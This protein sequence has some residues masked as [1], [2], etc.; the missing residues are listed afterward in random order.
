[1]RNKIIFS[2]TII[3]LGIMVVSLGLLPGNRGEEQVGQVLGARSEASELEMNLPS[4]GDL[5]SPPVKTN[6]YEP[7]ISVKAAI[8]VDAK[9]AYPLYQENEL[10]QVPIASTTKIMTAVI[11]LENYNVEDEIT[12]SSDATSTIGSSINLRAD[13]V[14]TVDSLLKG[15]LIQSGNDAA[16]TLAEKM[17]FDRFVS[18]MN[19][20]AVE[21]GMVNTAY[22]D[23]AGLNDEGYSTAK[24]LSILA[25]YALRNTKIKDIVSTEEMTVFSTDGQI[26][27]ELKNSNRLIR[28]DN[29]LYLEGAFGLKTGYT[30]EAGHC[31]V[32]SAVRDDHQ[33]ISVVLNTSENTVEASAKESRKLLSWGFETYKW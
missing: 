21:L 20:K 33:L 18:A 9:S 27:H 14:I 32:S 31:L 19:S 29:P 23:P 11:A 17:G 4:L 5:V 3:A 22:Q 7:P 15:L 2:L 10:E 8:L 12:V 6:D 25:S 26:S 16:V 24:D 13:E 30:P 1:M 28:K